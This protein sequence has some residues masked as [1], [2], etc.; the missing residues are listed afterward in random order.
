LKHRDKSRAP[1]RAN[2]LRVA[3]QSLDAQ[4]DDLR[5]EH[6]LIPVMTA[7]WMVGMAAMNWLHFWLGRN[8]NPWVLSVCAAVA[9]AYAGVKTVQTRRQLRDLRLGR[10]AERAVAQYLEWFRTAG[11]F[12]FHDVPNG[13]AN[14]DHVLVGPR[15]IYTI[16]TKAASKPV[17]GECKARVNEDGIRLNGHLMSR[18]PL[19]QAKA[20]ARWL[21]SFFREAQFAPFVQPVVVIPGWF[22]EP[23]DMRAVGVWVLEPK[24]LDAFIAKQPERLSRDEVRAMGS[25]LSSHIRAQSALA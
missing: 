22:I 7:V 12:V 16:E 14:I 2:P 5:M 18:N 1:L 21:H 6:G 23:F 4:I 9:A 25:A 10:D 11:F 13:D 24:A 20:Q 3:G 17:R 19:V 15:G 8:P